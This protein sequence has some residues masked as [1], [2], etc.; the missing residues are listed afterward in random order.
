MRPHRR[1]HNGT[2][3]KRARGRGSDS[4]YGI[5]NGKVANTG[6]GGVGYRS[7]HF[8][9]TKLGR[10][11]NRTK[12]MG[13]VSAVRETARRRS[14]CVWRG[15]RRQL[16]VTAVVDLCRSEERALRRC[17]I[18]IIEIAA[19]GLRFG[20]GFRCR[21]MIHRAGLEQSDTPH[22]RAHVRRVGNTKRRPRERSKNEEPD[23][24][25]YRGLHQTGNIPR[26][27]G[28]VKPKDT[29]CPGIDTQILKIL[30]TTT[31]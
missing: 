21:V 19:A 20:N 10:S 4:K 22:L 14:K 24:Y 11:R 27:A 13:R 8:H 3:R 26:M 5:R 18:R 7:T 1:V 29:P 28:F 12:T 31:L 17:I 6:R 25:G 15:K 9:R 30:T 16:G 23:R 2:W